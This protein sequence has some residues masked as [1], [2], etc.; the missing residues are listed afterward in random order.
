MENRRQKRRESTE[1]NGPY[2]AYADLLWFGEFLD[3]VKAMAASFAGRVQQRKPLTDI[4]TRIIAANKSSDGED[5]F[6]MQLLSTVLEVTQYSQGYQRL[7]TRPRVDS[8]SL[9]LKF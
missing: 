3:F 5:M 2:E 8:S 6:L 7:L 4:Q 1:Q 9:R